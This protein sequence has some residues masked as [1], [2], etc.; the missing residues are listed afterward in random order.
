MSSLP[1]FRNE[2]LTDFSNPANVAAFQQAI[3]LVRSQLGQQYPL[4]IGAN[5]VW[6]GETFDST[7]PAR[8]A[9]VVGTFAKGRKE[10]A[11]RAVTVAAEAF[12]TWRNTDPQERAR[13]LLRAAQEMRRRKHEFS[14]WMVFEIGKS[15]AEADADAAEAIDFLEYYAR[16]MMRLTSASEMLTDFPGEEA[17]LAYIP[18][19]V[20]AVIPPWN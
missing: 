6:T 7:N 2:P 9:E 1:E 5:D 16:Q 14:A 20:G 4:R 17:E 18:L 12:E 19:G 15:W 13:Y 11:E 3:D 8:P 10:D